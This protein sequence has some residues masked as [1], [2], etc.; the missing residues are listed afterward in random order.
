M[1]SR[2]TNLFGE[3]AHLLSDSHIYRYILYVCQILSQT[4]FAISWWFL[5]A[6]SILL[7]SIYEMLLQLKKKLVCG[8][9]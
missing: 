8:G 1:H 7:F 3:R 2:F 4:A 5:S 6:Q 9:G